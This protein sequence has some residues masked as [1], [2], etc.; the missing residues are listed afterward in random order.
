MKSFIVL[1]AIAAC[2]K[3]LSYFFMDL[4]SRMDIFS[5][6]FQALGFRVMS[7]YL[8]SFSAHRHIV[9]DFS[10]NRIRTDSIF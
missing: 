5:R 8:D 6:I 9:Q 7:H 1:V 4:L 3:Q 2:G 10:G